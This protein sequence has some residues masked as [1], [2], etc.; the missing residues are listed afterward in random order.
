[1]ALSPEYGWDYD[2]FLS[3]RGTD[4]GKG[5]A[6]NLYYALKQR[7]IRTFFADRELETGDKLTQTL[8]KKIQDSKIAIPVFSPEYADSAW[9]LLELAEIMD[10]MEEK[11]QLGFAVFHG[12]SASEV[13]RQKAKKGEK[14]TYEEAM[15]KH[16]SRYDAQ[17]VMKWRKA[18]EKAADLSSMSFKSKYDYEYEFVVKIIK[19][20]SKKL[21]RRTL[22]GFANQPFG[23]E[24]GV[25]EV[26]ELLEVGAGCDNKKV[27]RMVGIHGMGGIGKST[28]AKAVYNYIADQFDNRC[29][30][31]N[32][33]E[34]SSKHGL[35][36]QQ[37][38][39]L[40]K[41][42]GELDAKLGGTSEGME[43]IKRRLKKKKVLLILDDVDDKKQMEALAGGLDW[44]GSGS[45]VI[46]TTRDK[47]IILKCKWIEGKYELKGLSWED[48]RK[49]FEWMA[50]GNN[51]KVD[52]RL[53]NRAITYCANLPLAL[54][55]ISSE[56]S[57]RNVEEWEC[58]LDYYERSLD[59]GIYDE[60]RRSYD[61]LAKEVRDVFLDIACCFR[62]FSLTE[63]TEVLRAHHGFCPEPHIK[64]LEEKSLII[65]ENNRVRLHTLIHQMSRKLDHGY[66][67][68]LRSHEDIDRLFEDHKEYRHMKVLNFDCAESVR[69]IP[70]VSS[71]PSLEELSFAKCRNLIEVDNSVGKLRKLKILDASGCSKLRSF[72]SLML[73]CLEKLNLSSCS[74]LENFPKTLER[75][76]DLVKL[77][78]SSTAIKAIPAALFYDA[79]KLQELSFANCHGLNELDNS[80]GKLSYLKI[81]DA[82]GCSNLRSFPSPLRLPSLEKLDL[83]SCSS[84][85][86]F[87]EIP[88]RME[89][90]TRLRLQNSPI[91]KL[92]NSIRNLSLLQSLKMLGVNITFLPQCIIECL[93]LKKLNLDQCHDLKEI[94]WLPPNLETLSV[95]RCRSFEYLDLTILGR[96]TKEYYKLRRLVVDNCG[97]LQRI[98]GILPGAFSAT[99]CIC[100]PSS[101]PLNQELREE[102]GSMWHFVPGNR[103]P[104]WFHRRNNGDSISFWFQEKFPAISLCVFLGGLGKQQMPFYFCLKLKINGN[105]VNRWLLENK[106]YWFVQKLEADHVFFLHEKQMK[107]ENRL[108]KGLVGNKG[109]NGAE[110][111][112]DVYFPD[113]ETEIDI[114]IGIHIFKGKISMKDVLFPKP[115]QIKGDHN[116]SIVRLTRI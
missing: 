86:S 54:V 87:P 44:F 30:L 46:I 76:G 102:G 71:I 34:N 48:S 18:L 78:L 108:N 13:R 93:L 25:Q 22:V 70:D 38:T 9:C 56:L 19:E 27:V 72:P 111:F 109:W 67:F 104:E 61:P 106:K 113:G 59:K 43:L 60:L 115:Y 4:T 85:E 82:S 103:I 20:V 90:I 84:L 81:L 5:F 45:R 8:L 57:D 28:L 73:P 16:E 114:Q 110:I 2:V 37:E 49:L 65:I 69:V 112:V 41:I 21:L 23:L 12:V 31:E 98:E 40:S 68:C 66:R 42:V 105:T 89:K 33:S 36:R 32:V 88:A 99:N 3:F 14:G 24:S 17:T 100:L 10:N 55:S 52:Q 80:V 29:F 53:I 50:L 116:N 62:V 63:V 47:K 96:N 7:G 58:I 35:E 97:N 101:V 77:D 15:A 107:D 92:P 91:K 83:S 51:K 79:P 11:G 95:T 39:L 75:M 94:R 26:C 64:I 6:G 1:M 74:S